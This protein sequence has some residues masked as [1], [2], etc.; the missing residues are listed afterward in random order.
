M[1]A[2]IFNGTKI[3]EIKDFFQQREVLFGGSSAEKTEELNRKAFGFLAR[4]RKP[5]DPEEFYILG[6]SGKDI[7]SMSFNGTGI[8]FHLS[9]ILVMK[10][11]LVKNQKGHP[12]EFDCRATGVRLGDVVVS[13]RDIQG[14][15]FGILKIK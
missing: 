14:K 2:Q 12:P 15:L 6:F 4:S 7:L 9:D 10:T 5:K 8:S 13:V 11:D 1:E 3:E